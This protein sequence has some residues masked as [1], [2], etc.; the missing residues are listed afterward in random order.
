MQKR[1]NLTTGEVVLYDIDGKLYLKRGGENNDKW[2]ITCDGLS[3]KDKALCPYDL[4]LSSVLERLYT[5]I[6]LIN[7]LSSELLS[8]IETQSKIVEDDNR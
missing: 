6:L 8:E 4:P 2:L 5:K 7:M 1:I 3:I